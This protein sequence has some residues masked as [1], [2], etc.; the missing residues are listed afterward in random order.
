MRF[1][2]G[3]SLKDA[4]ERFHAKDRKPTS[5]SDRL[6]A[7]RKLL[8]R[9]VDVCQAVADVLS[10]PLGRADAATRIASVLASR[11]R[12]LL[13]LD[14]FEQVVGAAGATLGL[15]LDRA[16]D[17]RFL[18]TSRDRLASAASAASSCSARPGRCRRPVR[19]ARAIAA[20][21]EPLR[22]DTDLA[23][24]GDLV[25]LLEGL[26]LAIELAAARATAM[27]VSEMLQRMTDRFA[28]LVSSRS[29][30]Q[31]HSTLRARSTGRGARCP[32]DGRPRSRSCRCSKAASCCRRRSRSCGPRPTPSLP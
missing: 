13:I 27:S 6:L 31:G 10:V 29:R 14:N 1:I 20:R 28:L 22:T 26:P 7:F 5:D 18:V 25:Q 4:I 12:C 19:G 21:G 17:A 24:V 8:G 2:Q 3:D 11:G 15:W 32:R 16:E 30:R 9:F 23:A